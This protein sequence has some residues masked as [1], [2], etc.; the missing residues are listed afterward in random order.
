M[1]NVN[2][3]DQYETVHARTFEL[4]KQKLNDEV[5]DPVDVIHWGYM[6]NGAPFVVVAPKEGAAPKQRKQREKKAPGTGG[7]AGSAS[8]DIPLPAGAAAGGTEGDQQQQQ[9]PG[10]NPSVPGNQG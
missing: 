3:W 6:H 1:A 2:N 5:T 7:E 4:L 9:A 8:A 10:D